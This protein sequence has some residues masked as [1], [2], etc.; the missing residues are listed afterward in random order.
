M[1]IPVLHLHP[2]STLY[3]ESIMR[4]FFFFFFS[5]D[6]RRCCINYRLQERQKK[7]KSTSCVIHKPTRNILILRLNIL[8]TTCWKIVRKSSYFN[9]ICVGLVTFPHPAC[10]AVLAC[11]FYANIPFSKKIRMHVVYMFLFFSLQNCTQRVN[12]D[13]NMKGESSTFSLACSSHS[14]PH[15]LCIHSSVKE[16]QASL[17]FHLHKQKRTSG[18][19]ASGLPLLKTSTMSQ[20]FIRE[21]RR[22]VSDFYQYT[23]VPSVGCDVVLQTN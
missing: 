17:T 21:G 9:D 20:I 1:S 6:N 16:T 18:D 10:S 2:L 22:T 5:F 7:N 11:L 12:N 23:R 15:P 14:A 3:S 8:N 4:S 13:G 19:H